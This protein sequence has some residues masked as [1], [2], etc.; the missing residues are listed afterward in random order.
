ML[1]LF[2]VLPIV[3]AILAVFNKKVNLFFYGCVFAMVCQAVVQDILGLEGYK[4]F[5]T[6]HW[7]Q[8]AWWTWTLYTLAML[9]SLSVLIKEIRRKD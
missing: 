1:L 5:I 3:L 8:A 6:A 9:I 7:I 4:T 2:V